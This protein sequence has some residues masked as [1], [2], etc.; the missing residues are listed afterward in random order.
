[1][2]NIGLDTNGERKISMEDFI[3]WW[4]ESN[5]SGDALLLMI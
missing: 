1:M 4:G 5:T 2:I 3:Q